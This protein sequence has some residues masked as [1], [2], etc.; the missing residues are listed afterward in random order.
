MQWT[1]ATRPGVQADR[2]PRSAGVAG[3]RACLPAPWA[4]VRSGERR[5]PSECPLGSH[6]NSG[7]STSTRSTR[8]CFRPYGSPMMRIGLPRRPVAVVGSGLSRRKHPKDGSG[9]PRCDEMWSA[10]Q[11]CANARARAL[12]QIDD[13][14][15][16]AWA[17]SCR[18]RHRVSSARCGNGNRHR[19]HPIRRPCGSCARVALQA[20]PAH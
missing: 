18:V 20:C 5:K 16:R 15:T 13:V 11:A 12:P 8:S 2:F 19:D 6:C 9:A 7:F 10:R 4:F 1:A 3:V 14:P 17:H